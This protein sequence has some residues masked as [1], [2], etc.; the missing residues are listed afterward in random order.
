MEARQAE[1]GRKLSLSPPFLLLGKPSA[2]LYLTPFHSQEEAKAAA[3]SVPPSSEASPGRT[4]RH[5]IATAD[6]L[7]GRA[8]DSFGDSRSHPFHLRP[9]R[10]PASGIPASTIRQVSPTRSSQG[11][12]NVI[13]P[14]PLSPSQTG[15]RK[16]DPFARS[17]VE[18]DTAA[19]SRWSPET[20]R[21]DCERSLQPIANVTRRVVRR[22]RIATARRI[23]PRCA[24]SPFSLC[25]L[26][27]ARFH[28][29]R[30]LA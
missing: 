27:D 1:D 8:I 6:K 23:L 28:R 2:R 11:H 5:R 24:F 3:A 30:Y 4:L 26:P 15:Q 21:S 22:K 14:I 12:P 25:L 17:A 18:P 20:V 16:K 19:F 9:P 10:A 29:A 13:R 7:E